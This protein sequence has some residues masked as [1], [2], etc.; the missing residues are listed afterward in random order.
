[1]KQALQQ[2][3]RQQG[4]TIKM[5]RPREPDSCPARRVRLPPRGSA[6]DGSFAGDS[7]PKAVP[8]RKP[9]PY[10]V[11]GR[12]VASRGWKRDQWNQSTP[13]TFPSSIHHKHDMSHDNKSRIEHGPSERQTPASNSISTPIP[14]VDEF[15][16]QKQ[17]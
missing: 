16:R 13:R 17:L 8:K 5:S 3:Q 4:G 1:L 14:H 10:A 6:T 12:A 2:I 15:G 11:D 7:N 9:R